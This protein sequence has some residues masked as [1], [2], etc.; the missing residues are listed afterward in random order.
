VPGSVRSLTATNSTSRLRA[1]VARS[2]L[3]PIPSEAVDSDTQGHG[4]SFSG[5]RGTYGERSSGHGGR[6]QPAPVLAPAAPTAA[7]FTSCPRAMAVMRAMRRW[8]ADLL[9][10]G[11]QSAASSARDASGLTS[12]ARARARSSSPS[13]AQPTRATACS[14]SLQLC[15]G[16]PR[17]CGERWPHPRWTA[18]WRD[19]AVRDD[20]DDRR[21]SVGG[22][23]RHRRVAAG[24]SRPCRT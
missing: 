11:S 3:R 24:R 17:R 10:G 16:R 1:R 22:T 9:A 23:V 20:P 19:S 5:T 6:L 2:R 8:T 18:G 4:G 7:W 13:P 14:M 12:R 21:S 15:P